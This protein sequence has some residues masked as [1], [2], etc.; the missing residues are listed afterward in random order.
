M[1]MMRRYLTELIIIY[2]INL[3]KV[4]SIIYN[5]IDRTYLCLQL[6]KL[7]PSDARKANNQNHKNA[8]QRPTGANPL[9]DAASHRV[10]L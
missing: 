5:N 7:H 10:L 6:S 4:P 8:H 9:F 1:I 3:N 2:F